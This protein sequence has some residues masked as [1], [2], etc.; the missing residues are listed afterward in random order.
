MIPSAIKNHVHVLCSNIHASTY[1][2]TL[3]KTRVY[4][5]LNESNKY[6]LLPKVREWYKDS[7]QYNQDLDQLLLDLFP[8]GEKH[9]KYLL[10]S[11]EPYESSYLSSI[12]TKDIQHKHK[13]CYKS[14]EN[15]Y[16]SVVKS[17]DYSRSYSILCESAANCN[18]QQT[19]DAFT[20]Y[21]GDIKR[22][23]TGENKELTSWL[24]EKF[25]GSEASTL[26]NLI[27]TGQTSYSCDNTDII[28]AQIASVDTAGDDSTSSSPKTT[29]SDG[30][31]RKNMIRDEFEKNNTPHYQAYNTSS[32]LYTTLMMSNLSEITK[33]TQK[34]S[35]LN[36]MMRQFDTSCDSIDKISG[37]LT[38]QI[39]ESPDAQF[40]ENDS[41]KLYNRFL[42]NQIGNRG[43]T[44][45]NIDKAI[46]RDKPDDETSSN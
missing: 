29:I 34:H 39:T 7:E 33:N 3:D 26:N 46:T 14:A 28:S 22:E 5:T 19:L 25:T 18:L 24:S 4:N 35:H 37:L 11:G 44:S 13:T 41:I 1:L 36:C 42:L 27:S 40:T 32:T 21:F 16:F 20:N 8:S 23:D 9:V 12:G 30:S 6:G 43:L 38:G 45:D 31:A 17:P 2:G 10:Q 15:L